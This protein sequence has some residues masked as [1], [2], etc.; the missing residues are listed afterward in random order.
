MG[1]LDKQAERL[2][3]LSTETEAKRTRL[4]GLM[5]LA[6]ERVRPSHLASEAGNKVLDAGLD[7]IDASKA[8]V[9]A[10]PFKAAGIAAAIGAILARNP[11]FSLAAKGYAHVRA[12]MT[13]QQDAAP[14]PPPS[15]TED[16]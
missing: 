11:L 6:R 8:A 12:G 10:H 3:T 5:G 14:D 13:R 9:R 2:A 16:P 15:Q 4:M 7:A 1:S